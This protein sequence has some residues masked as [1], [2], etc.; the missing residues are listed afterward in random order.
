MDQSDLNKA[1]L[2]GMLALSKGLIEYSDAT[3]GMMKFTQ[4]QISKLAE[5]CDIEGFAEIQSDFRSILAQLETRHE[6]AEA[7]LQAIQ[8]ALDA[9]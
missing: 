1:M 5:N 8:N 3:V 9:L 2:R 4:S 6:T 7:E